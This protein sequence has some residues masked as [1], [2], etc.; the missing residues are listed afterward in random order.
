VRTNPTNI[1]P[2]SRLWAVCKQFVSGFGFTWGHLTGEGVLAAAENTA[3]DGFISYSHAADDL[4]APRLQAGL[5]RFAKPWWKRRAL[6]VFRDEASLSANP[7]L[8]SS[9]TRAL[10]G[11]GWFVLLLSEEGAQS[12]WVNR[13]I[14]YWVTNKDPSRIIPVVTDGE[15]G[16][17]QGE[18]DSSS[19][20]APPALSGVFVEEPRWVDLRWAR[21]DTQLDLNNARFRDAVANI[22]SAMRGIPKDELESEEV[23]QHRRTIR[24]AWAAGVVVLLLGIAATVGAV[25]AVGQSNEAQDQRDKAQRQAQIA[26]DSEERALS[27]EG[28]A[29]EQADIAT[30]NELRALDAEADAREQAAVAQ[31]E[32]DTAQDERDSADDITKRLLDFFVQPKVTQA[33]PPG[34]EPIPGDPLGSPTPIDVPP[35]TARLDF[36]FT[37]GALLRGQR[38]T[39]YREA[40]FVHPVE[41]LKIHHFWLAGRPFHIRHGFANADDEPVALDGPAIPGF[42]LRLFVTRRKGPPLGDGSFVVGQTYQFRAD[43]RLRDM[44][45]RCGPLSPGNDLPAATPC[46]MFVHDFPD[47]LPPGTYDFWLE[48]RAPCTA[49]VPGKEELCG[50]FNL[51]LDLFVSQATISFMSDDFFE[52]PV[53]GLATA[54]FDWPFEPW[55]YAEPL[56]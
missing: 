7:H 50:G 49:W 29:L 27:A 37:E 15:F 34:A 47:G 53:I 54:S 31:T 45:D 4:L 3:Y 6:R 40:A 13:E 18:I 38:G 48:W 24:T 8:W 46:D 12:E 11:S 2:P 9:I 21:S 28:D 1:I 19:S 41:A 10:D 25:V 42:D 36:L 26:S 22:A 20:A 55:D 32:R 35:D 51:A 5:Q 44:S 39:A 52:D 56:P 33:L 30:R 43:Y 17:N 16:W 14:G 23:R